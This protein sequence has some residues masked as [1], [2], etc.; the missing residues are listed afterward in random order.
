[1]KYHPSPPRFGDY[2]SSLGPSP[3]R[4]LVIIVR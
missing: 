3:I 4:V 2:G 1:L